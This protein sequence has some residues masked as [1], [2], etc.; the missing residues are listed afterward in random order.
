MAA[1]QKHAKAFF[2]EGAMN[3]TSYSSII[4]DMHHAR[5]QKLLKGTSGQVVMGGRY[6]ED[7][8]RRFEPTVV[9]D[10]KDGDALMD[11]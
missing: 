3:S 1:L 9:S 11:E 5:L 8:S 2:P 10:V 7:G 6:M 4:S